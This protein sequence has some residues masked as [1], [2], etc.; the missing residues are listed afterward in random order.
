MFYKG[1]KYL[2]VDGEDTEVN[3]KFG[4]FFFF[5]LDKSDFPLYVTLPRENHFIRK[6]ECLLMGAIEIICLIYF[7][8]RIIFIFPCTFKILYF[9]VTRDLV[10]IHVIFS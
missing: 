10:R 5:Q 2:L 8:F 4:F 9:S 3:E 1:V 7:T 6:R